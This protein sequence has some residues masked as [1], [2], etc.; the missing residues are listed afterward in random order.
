VIAVS[1]AGRAYLIR[2]RSKENKSG[3]DWTAQLPDE[4]I[5]AATADAGGLLQFTAHD[6]QA[7]AVVNKFVSHP[8]NTFESQLS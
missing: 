4:Q 3:H 6:E 7:E 1:K 2:Q 5:A 8:F